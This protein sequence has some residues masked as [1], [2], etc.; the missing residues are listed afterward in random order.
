MKMKPNDRLYILLFHFKNKTPF[1]NFQRKPILRNNNISDITLVLKIKVLQ[2]FSDTYLA[3][4]RYATFFEAWQMFRLFG[5][6][7]LMNVFIFSKIRRKHI[8]MHYADI[9]FMNG[10]PI[11]FCKF[12][13]VLFHKHISSRSFSTTWLFHLNSYNQVRFGGAISPPI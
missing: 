7:P 9:V 6:F 13:K 11:F 10:T 5:I 8:F 1:W 12:S 4:I 2:Q 3:C